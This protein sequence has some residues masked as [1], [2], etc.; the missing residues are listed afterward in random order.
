MT[1]HATVYKLVPGSEKEYKR[2]HDNIWPELSKAIDHQGL[3]NYTIW[4]YEDILFAYYEIDE[5]N[6]KPP[7]P[8]MIELGNKW[9]EYM[10]DILIP[11]IDEKTK[12]QIELKLMFLHE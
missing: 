10:K 8:E 7:T 1:R 11:V 4:L 3:R 2:R 5:E 6:A 9:S 12:E